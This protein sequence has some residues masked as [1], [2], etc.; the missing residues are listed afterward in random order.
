MAWRCQNQGDRQKQ[1]SPTQD[2]YCLAIHK[3]P[4]SKALFRLYKGTE[5][6]CLRSHAARNGIV[7][8][9]CPHI[10]RAETVCKKDNCAI[11]THW[12]LVVLIIEAMAL[13]RGS[14]L[15]RAVGKVRFSIRLCI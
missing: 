14:L 8:L 2:K 5:A 4:E 1:G 11:V 15:P 10:K 6:G 9:L 12:I 13:C 3:K 7:P